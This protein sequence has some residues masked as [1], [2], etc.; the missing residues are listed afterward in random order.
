MQVCNFFQRSRNHF[1]N[2]LLIEI[3]GR[4]RRAQSR[5]ARRLVA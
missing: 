3:Q 1:Y 5:L 2:G 4:N